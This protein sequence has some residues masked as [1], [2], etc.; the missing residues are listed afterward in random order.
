MPWWLGAT[1]FCVRWSRV[2]IGLAILVRPWWRIS[3]RRLQ[4]LPGGPAQYGVFF[5]FL[6]LLFSIIFEIFGEIK[7]ILRFENFIFEKLFRLKICSIR[8]MFTF[9]FH[10]QIRKKCSNSNLFRF[11]FVQTRICLDLNLFKL[12]FVQIWICSNSILLR[13]E[14][15]QTQFCSNA[16]FWI[17]HFL[18]LNRFSNKNR[19]TEKKVGKKKKARPYWASPSRNAC[20]RRPAEQHTERPIGASG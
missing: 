16:D 9:E 3:H 7:K 19:F 13:F 5:L 2:W 15:V 1:G 10:I 8:N 6:L 14:F 12:N 18:N 17:E 4:A 11:K 20:E